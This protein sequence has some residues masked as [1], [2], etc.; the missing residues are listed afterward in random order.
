MSIKSISLEGLKLAHLRQLQSYIN[1][2]DET[3]W[4]YGSRNHFEKRHVD[5]VKWINLAVRCA[6]SECVKNA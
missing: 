5:L 6:E 2:R 1:S 3:G 4:Y